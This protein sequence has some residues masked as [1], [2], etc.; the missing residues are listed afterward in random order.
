MAAPEVWMALPIATWSMSAGAMPARSVP[1]RAATGASSI[2]EA[3][4]RAP[5]GS[6]SPR[7]PPIHSAIGVRAPETITISGNP[8]LGTGCSWVVRGG[9]SRRRTRRRGR[10]ATGLDAGPGLK[11]AKPPQRLNEGSH[12]PA[13]HGAGPGSR[14]SLTS[15]EVAHRPSVHER[16]PAAPG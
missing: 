14:A 13:A 7:L 8:L 3:D 5:P 9:W 4:A 11:V 15:H 2:A 10:P 1:A 16:A 12:R 6:P